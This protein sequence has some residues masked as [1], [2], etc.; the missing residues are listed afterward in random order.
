MGANGAAISGSAFNG[1]APTLGLAIT[2]G[3]RRYH[4]AAN[5]DL[6][7]VVT[8]GFLV[9]VVESDGCSCVGRGTL[10]LDRLLSGV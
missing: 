3:Q 7:G 5:N 9:D 2:G 4:G 10:S 6:L 8:A 1:G